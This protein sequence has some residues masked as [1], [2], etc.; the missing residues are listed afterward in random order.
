[1]MLAMGSWVCP[2]GTGNEGQHPSA[3]VAHEHPS[4]LHEV[5]MPDRCAGGHWLLAV[6]ESLTAEDREILHRMARLMA[7]ERRECL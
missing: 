3:G 7:A 2:T 6:P 5:G 1:M 4:A